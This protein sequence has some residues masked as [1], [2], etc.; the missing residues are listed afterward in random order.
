VAEQLSRALFHHVL[1]S[2]H[3]IK[4]DTVNPAARYAYLRGRYLWNWRT[5]PEAMFNAMDQF[6][7]ATELDPHHAR[8]YS[9][10][11]D[12]YAVLGWMAAI[13]RKTAVEGAR[14]A[15]L[16]ALALDAMLSEAHVSLGYVLFDYDWDWEGAEREL[17]LGIE[18][19]P[20]NAQGYCWYGHVLEALGRSQE[21]VNAAQTAQDMDPASPVVNLFLRRGDSA[22]STRAEHAAGLRLRAVLARLSLRANRSAAIRDLPLTGCGACARR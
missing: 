9:G 16:R 11:A 15:A 17:L 1:M 3:E 21:A 20:A 19:N 7:L 5:S 2:R 6:R 14:K 4:S 8:A 18:L 10:L 22:V 12:C 13:P